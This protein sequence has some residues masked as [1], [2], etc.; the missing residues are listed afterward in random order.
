M[1]C[2]NVETISYFIRPLTL[3][4]AISTYHKYTCMLYSVYYSHTV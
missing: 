4:I 3:L 2:M 1:Q